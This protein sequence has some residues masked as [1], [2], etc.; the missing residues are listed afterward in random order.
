MFEHLSH[1]QLLILM[2][3]SQSPMYWLL[4]RLHHRIKT[5]LRLQQEHEMLIRWYCE[6]T[7]TKPEA[8]ITRL[9]LLWENGT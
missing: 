1:W 3:G 8:L 5:N 2:I 4:G 7:G 6:E 9:K